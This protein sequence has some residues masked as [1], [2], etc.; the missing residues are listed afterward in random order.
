[1]PTMKCFLKLSEQ[2][3]IVALPAR[4]I[5]C[6]SIASFLCHRRTPGRGCARRVQTFMPCELLIPF[7]SIS[8]I[9]DCFQQGC[10]HQALIFHSGLHTVSNWQKKK[11]FL[12]EAQEHKKHTNSRT[13][14]DRDSLFCHIGDVQCGVL[15]GTSTFHPH[16]P[17]LNRHYAC[18]SSCCHSNISIY[19]VRQL[20]K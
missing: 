15:Y 7:L 1:M 19:S 6:F 11:L 8:Q 10:N 14:I 17:D 13:R 18:C 4:Q 9:P 5:I 3:I 20:Y 2:P 12:K 16:F